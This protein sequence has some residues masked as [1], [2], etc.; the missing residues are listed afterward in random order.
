VMEWCTCVISI[1]DGLKITVRDKHGDGL[2]I[3][4]MRKSLLHTLILQASTK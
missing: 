1:E 2:K 4:I 3:T